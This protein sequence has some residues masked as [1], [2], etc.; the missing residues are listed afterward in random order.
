MSS[1]DDGRHVLLVRPGEQGIEAKIECLNDKENVTA[2]CN[3]EGSCIV[4]YDWENIGI[5]LLTVQYQEKD[6]N[7]QPLVPLLYQ[8]EGF[9]EDAESWVLPSKEH[10]LNG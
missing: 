7:W 4:L 10:K 8:I 1:H 9:G 2:W 3:R 5:D 6:E